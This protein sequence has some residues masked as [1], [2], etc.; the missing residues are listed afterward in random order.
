MRNASPVLLVA[1]V[2]IAG[3]GGSG[4]SA[5]T[6]TAAATPTYRM[7]LTAQRPTITRGRSV[8]LHATVGGGATGGAVPVELWSYVPGHP[9]GARRVASEAAARRATFSVR[10]D[11]T[12]AYE[13]RADHGRQHSSAELVGVNLPGHLQ[14][15]LV[16]AGR[17]R[18]TLRLRAPS[19]ARPNRAA[20]VFL[21]IA[22]ARGGAVRM[23]P[24]TRLRR[25]AP[26]DI[27][28]TWTAHV[29]RPDSKDRFYACARE[30]FVSG[31]GLSDARDTR[32]GN[33][34]RTATDIR[35]AIAGRA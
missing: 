5:R 23:L 31:F 24:S 7:A 11:R 12:L 2:G 16:G 9:D 25:V 3:C 32:C 18:F 10:P 33:A 30:A 35:A 17:A 6:T 28:A 27:R 1:I 13:L 21:Y 29:A 8:V 34:D 15:R 19:G 4:G 14:G 22:P 26:G 20:R